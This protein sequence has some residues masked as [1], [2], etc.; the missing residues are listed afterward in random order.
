MSLVATKRIGMSVL[1]LLVSGILINFS[2]AEEEKLK[3]GDC[4]IARNEE[5][6]KIENSMVCNSKQAGITCLKKNKEK[7]EFDVVMTN[8]SCTRIFL[9]KDC[10]PPI[11]FCISTEVNQLCRYSHL[12]YK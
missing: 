11:E 12:T 9:D 2:I 7:D 8:V 4:Y 10:L 1:F 3:C 5:G 6:A